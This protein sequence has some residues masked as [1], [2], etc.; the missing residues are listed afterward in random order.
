ME[1]PREIKQ[2]ILKQIF[3]FSFI[4]VYGYTVNLNVD[5]TCNFSL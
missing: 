4:S 5:H 3:G 1:L 2:Y